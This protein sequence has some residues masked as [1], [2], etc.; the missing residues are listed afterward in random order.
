MA[1][2]KVTIQKLVDGIV[3]L[4]HTIVND[5]ESAIN[6]AKHLLSLHKGSSVKVT[7]DSGKVITSLGIPTDNSYST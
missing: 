1:N 4:E 2:F 5:I 6:H 7:D 3:K